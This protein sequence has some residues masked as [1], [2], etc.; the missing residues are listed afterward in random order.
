MKHKSEMQSLQPFFSNVI[1]VFEYYFHRQAILHFQFTAFL[2][3]GNIEEVL[4]SFLS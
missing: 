3:N 1:L 2:L 4:E